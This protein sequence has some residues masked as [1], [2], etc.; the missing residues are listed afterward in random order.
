[1]TRVILRMTGVSLRRK[2]ASANL[3]CI[4]ST[5]S[6]IIILLSQPLPITTYL[7]A[8]PHSHAQKIRSEFSATSEPPPF[9]QSFS[10]MLSLYIL[11]IFWL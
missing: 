2:V 7:T 3:S 11:T 10:S 6:S 4:L 8:L 5:L 1:M 9:T